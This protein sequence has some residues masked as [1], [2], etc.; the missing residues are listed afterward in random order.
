MSYVAVVLQDDGVSV[1]IL[2]GTDEVSQLADMDLPGSPLTQVVAH[3]R[4]LAIV[5]DLLGT[6]TQRYLLKRLL[7]RDATLDDF[8]HL[9]QDEQGEVRRPLH[10]GLAQ[11]KPPTSGVGFTN[12]AHLLLGFKVPAARSCSS[13]S[14]SEHMWVSASYPRPTGK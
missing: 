8:A 5:K 7:Y 6:I 10:S 1:L 13:T 12:L 9:V 14:S 4:L 2:S 11:L 3:L